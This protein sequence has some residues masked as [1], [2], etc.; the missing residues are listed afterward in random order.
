MKRAAPLLALML[1]PALCPAQGPARAPLTPAAAV[2]LEARRAET[3]AEVKTLAS[4]LHERAVCALYPAN[5][6]G[7]PSFK[8][9]ARGNISIDAT[10]QVDLK[11]YRAWVAELSPRLRRLAERSEQVRLVKERAGYRFELPGREFDASQFVVVD[12]FSEIPAAL[13]AHVYTFDI[14]TATEIRAAFRPPRDRKEQTVVLM[15]FRGENGPVASVRQAFALASGPESV[16]PFVESRVRYQRFG[17]GVK[18]DKF[19]VLTFKSRKVLRM[20]MSKV[21][22]ASLRAMTKAWTVCLPAAAADAAASA[23]ETAALFRDVHGRV[24]HPGRGSGAPVASAAAAGSETPSVSAAEEDARRRA[25][26]ARALRQR[27]DAATADAVRT[28]AESFFAAV[29]GGA[30]GKP[31][32]AA[33]EAFEREDLS[34][35]CVEAVR[36][37]PGAPELQVSGEAY[38]ASQLWAKWRMRAKFDDGDGIVPGEPVWS[39]APTFQ[40]PEYIRGAAR[41]NPFPELSLDDSGSEPVPDAPGTGSSFPFG[42]FLLATGAVLLFAGT[43]VLLWIDRLRKKAEEAS[44]SES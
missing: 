16:A 3:L 9:D 18:A 30:R 29:R 33:I 1:L 4:Q 31:A 20:P 43:I 44:P 28:S 7:L 8:S 38:L 34:V 24:V 41:A 17:S 27:A 10:V 6:R 23:S 22:T 15:Q 40:P 13:G 25:A 5:A 2:Q 11:A 39:L 14:A 42:P 35:A 36:E 32:A 21:E 37:H 12:G 26:E 19:P